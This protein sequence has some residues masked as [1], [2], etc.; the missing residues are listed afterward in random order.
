MKN[1]KLILIVSLVLAMTMSLGGTLAYLSDTDADVNTMVLGNVTIVQNE[2]ER[3]ADG[4][5]V[6]FTQNKPLLPAVYDS[7]ML[8]QED[9]GTK[10]PVA[11]V[12]AW[13]TYVDNANVVDKFVTV[14][15]KGNTD[16]YV[17]TIIAYEGNTFEN[18]SLQRN[19]Y[20]NDKITPFEFAGLVS[21]HGKT[22]F[23]QV[24]TYKD[25]LGA[26]ETS[27]PSLKQVYLKKEAKNDDLK[28]LDAN[29]NGTYDI[30]V[31]SQAVQANGFT[32][33]NGNGTA[34]DDALNA[35]FNEGKALTPDVIA[36]WFE[37]LY[38]AEGEVNQD[39]IGSPNGDKNDTNNPPY[40]GVNNAEDLKNAAGSSTVG[41]VDLTENYDD[42]NP[43]VG[44]S[45]GELV[46][47]LNGNTMDAAY[48]QNNG[49]M[50]VNGEGGTLVVGSASNYGGISQGAD[51]VATYN[52]VNIT[53]AGGGV[54][55]A[56][57]AQVTFNSGSVEVDSKSTSGRY[58]FYAEGEGSVI[59]INGGSFDF[60]KTQNQKRAYI[61][62]G[63]GTT[64]YVNGGTF[65]KASTR[66]GYTAGILGEGTVIITG[67]TFGFNPS[68]WVA[69]GY[70]ATQNDST[71]TV[72]AE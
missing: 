33:V 60:N 62:A 55:A 65:G 61:Y 23:V 6:E 15:N 18:D 46:I 37:E 28:D 70:V 3:D 45:Q 64:V 30:L 42:E 31:I 9:D 17:R 16:A 69:D 56:N 10:W 41:V 11:N 47:N 67:G 26:K 34:A 40:V 24:L 63:A 71:W 59:T 54:A 72:A 19:I 48:L 44:D 25:A 36:A 68:A 1:R 2:Q 49:V 14:T 51:A 27:T 5:L 52:N 29:G 7:P 50:E 12:D 43:V 35:G 66:S 53:S 38:S 32:D 58:L 21:I 13:Q 20:T 22:Y 4:N 39:M 8:S 57:G